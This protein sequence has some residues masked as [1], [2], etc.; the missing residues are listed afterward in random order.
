MKEYSL[1]DVIKGNLNDLTANMFTCIPCVIIRV[2]ESLNTQMVDVQPVINKKGKNGSDTQSPP[3]LAVPVVFPSSK[4]SAFTF[5]INV[6]DTVMCVFSQRGLDSF[7]SGNGTF[8][9][10]TDYRKFDKRDA[11]AVPGLFPFSEAINNPSKHTLPHSTQDAVMV[12]NIGTGNEV[13]VRLKKDGKV[14]IT[15]PVEVIVN[16]PKTTV[17]SDYTIVN[18]SSGTFNIAQSEWNGNITFNGN[19]VQ[20][21]NLTVW[22]MFSLDDVNMNAHVH[23]GVQTGPSNSGPPVG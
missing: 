5:P 16:A 15:S 8:S 3:I 10:P 4:T 9:S 13:E 19:I 2:Y 14:Q 12:H 6:G 17:N 7:K 21:G 20:E 1:V 11:I 23:S 18:S 22:G